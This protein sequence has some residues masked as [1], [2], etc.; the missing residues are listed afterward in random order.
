LAVKEGNDYV[1]VWIGTHDEYDHLIGRG[2]IGELRAR[3]ETSEAGDLDILVK[4]DEPRK[5]FDS[6]MDIQFVLEDLFP[7]T[8]VDLVLED[9]LKPAVRDRVLSEARNVA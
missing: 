5:T 7:E 8:N 2:V 6:L 1:R 3:G 4:L 9:A